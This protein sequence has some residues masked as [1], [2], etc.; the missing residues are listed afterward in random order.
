MI[1][2]KEI[3]KKKD[4]PF[5]LNSKNIKMDLLH[6]KDD[7]L[8]DI[9]SMQ[10]NIAD[11]FTI[12]NNLLKEKLESYDT[13]INLYNEKIIQLSNLIT[14][15]NNLKE[16]VD[17]LLSTKINFQDIS[18]FFLQKVKGVSKKYYKV[19]V[20]DNNGVEKIISIGQDIKCDSEYDQRLNF[21]P[22]ILRAYLKPGEKNIL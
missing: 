17:K 22:Y 6:F 10:K 12:S 13:K 5:A 11:K 15:D 4:D 16:K 9:K 2:D 3:D 19:G 14:E 18:G 1:N 8:K 20:K 21:I 7:I